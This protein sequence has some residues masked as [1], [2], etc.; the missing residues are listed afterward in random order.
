MYWENGNV[1]YV[2]NYGRIK[3]HPG[4]YISPVGV[5]IFYAQEKAGGTLVKWFN[6]RS[7]WCASESSLM[8]FHLAA[9]VIWGKRA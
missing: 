8:D 5:C 9:L 3:G 4:Q 2:K 6:L 7:V 1:H